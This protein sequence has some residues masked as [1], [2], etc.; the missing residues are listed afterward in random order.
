MPRSS[1]PTTLAPI[2]D[3]RE[4]VQK[5]RQFLPPGGAQWYSFYSSVLG[6]IVINPHLFLV[7]LDDHLVHRG[8]A[9]FDTCNVVAG[10]AY[11]LDFHLDRLLRNATLARIEHPWCKEDLREIILKT[12]AA[13]GKR[14]DVMAKFFMSVGRGNFSISPQGCTAATL[15][16]LVHEYKRGV[17][18]VKEW[19]VE[20]SVVPLKPPLLATVKS[21]NYMLNALVSMTAQDNGGTLGIQCDESGYVTECSI[22]NLAIVDQGGVLRTPK[23]DNILAGTTVKRTFV[24]APKLLQAGLIE[25]FEFGAIHVSELLEAREV[26]SCGGGFLTPI[27]A[28]NNKEVGDGTPGPVYKAM[29][30]VIAKDMETPEY[31]DDIPYQSYM[32]ERET[33][34][35]SACYGESKLKDGDTRDEVA[36]DEGSFYIYL[37]AAVGS[38]ALMAAF[39]AG[40]VTR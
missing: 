22:G 23:F 35:R 10:K 27:I 38:A 14:C 11:G 33:K 6:G 40:R 13:S 15:Y 36:E 24:L 21:T 1:S 26:I 32:G 30:T 18:G 39:L 20:P 3:E 28:V 25:G 4:V 19:V 16:V 12:I 7:P 37:Y 8:H 31:L 17:H 9:V 34:A 29:F 5:L 2:L